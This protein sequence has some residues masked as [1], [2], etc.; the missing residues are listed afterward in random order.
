MQPSWGKSGRG[1]GYAEGKGY[2][3]G[4]FSW[5]YAPTERRG[6]GYAD[7]E[8]GKGSAEGGRGKAYSAAEDGRGKGAAPTEGGRG[9]GFAQGEG[10]GGKGGKASASVASAAPALRG[11][12]T[13]ELMNV[14]AELM[15]MRPDALVRLSPRELR[16]SQGSSLQLAISSSAPRMECLIVQSDEQAGSDPAWTGMSISV[17]S[18]LSSATHLVSLTLCR[19]PLSG[20]KALAPL[21]QLNRLRVL[22]LEGSPALCTEALREL[23][24]CTELQLV[25]FNGCTAFEDQAVGFLMPMQQLHSLHLDYTQCADTS[26]LLAT[27]FPKLCQLHMAGTAVTDHG[28]RVLCKRAS[29]T[30]L[31]MPECHRLTDEGIALLTQQVRAPQIEHPSRS[32]AREPPRSVM[33]SRASPP[34]AT[35][36]TMPRSHHR[37][38]SCGSTSAVAPASTPQ[39]SDSSVPH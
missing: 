31:R 18:P 17:P 30:E 3:D 32:V 14:L 19:L 23:Q 22:R 29:L 16:D 10:G 33:A 25:S 26:L 20:N 28:L 12:S 4:G 11:G 34:C 8:R 13:H 21:S 1:K 15:D 6:K 39:L 5:G 35:R 2:A 27:V 7:G 9:Q 37:R 36:L 24:G 38:G